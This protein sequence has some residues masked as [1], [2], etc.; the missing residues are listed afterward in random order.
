MGIHRSLMRII[1]WVHQRAYVPLI[2]FVVFFLAFVF[3]CFAVVYAALH[4]DGITFLAGL[5][6][7]YQTGKGLFVLFR[8]LLEVS[9]GLH[10]QE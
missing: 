3:G 7:A 2:F 8:A 4:R 9:K 10:E 1:A 6:I 5:L